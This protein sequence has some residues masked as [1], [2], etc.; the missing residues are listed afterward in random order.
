MVLAD[1]GDDPLI[2]SDRPNP[3]GS[4]PARATQDDAR[5]GRGRPRAAPAA[6]RR[7]PR[8]RRIDFHDATAVAR[9]S[10]RGRAV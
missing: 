6:V 7:D 8:R 4:E 3:T 2:L 9:R 10:R 1:P 5:R